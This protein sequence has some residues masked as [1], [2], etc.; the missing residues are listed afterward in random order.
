MN[1]AREFKHIGQ[2]T[3]RPDGFDKVT[4]KANYGADLSLPGMIWGAILRSP[5]AHANIKKLDVSRAEASPD[6]LAIAT[7]E[8]FP[9]VNAAAQRDGTH[10]EGMMDT[11]CNILANQKVLYHG[12]AV[13][14][15]AAR[16][17][18]AAIAALDLIDVEYEV[19][20]PVL[21]IDDAISAT[22]PTSCKASLRTDWA[23]RKRSTWWT[24]CSS[25]W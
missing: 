3:I 8:D 7:F 10:R 21:N 19:L 23:A 11:A 16:S 2:R 20:T 6:V 9:S 24:P 12:H 4:G 13:A 5:H 1:E 25:A 15:I 14:A 22:A 18:A 17:Q